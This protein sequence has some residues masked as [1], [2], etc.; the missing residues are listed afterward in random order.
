MIKSLSAPM[1]SCLRRLNGERVPNY[2]G[3][4][5][6][7][8]RALEKRGLIEWTYNGTGGWQLTDAGREA[9]A[10]A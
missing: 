4:T 9:I 2:G 10:S 6:Q 8:K 1:L 7:T 3:S 5:T